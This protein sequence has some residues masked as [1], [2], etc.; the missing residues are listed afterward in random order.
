MSL[1]V[2]P[3]PRAAEPKIEACVGAIPSLDMN[4][5]TDVVSAKDAIALDDVKYVTASR[6]TRE[7]KRPC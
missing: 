1:R 4:H 7:V 6:T 2:S 3:M 5:A